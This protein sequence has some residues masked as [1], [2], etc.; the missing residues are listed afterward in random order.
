MTG[1]GTLTP[2][3]AYWIQ[4]VTNDTLAPSPLGFSDCG[5]TN[6]TGSV[7]T[8]GIGT[9]AGHYGSLT[10]GAPYTSMPATLTAGI[11]QPTIYLNLSNATEPTVATPVI[12]PNSTTFTG[13]ESVSITDS[14]SGAN[15]HYTLDGTTPTSSSPLYTST[16]MLNA[17]TTVNAIAVA[18]SY[19]PSSVASATYT[20]TGAALVSNFLGTAT[21]NNFTVPGSPVQFTVFLNY[22]DGVQTSITCV[23]A[24]PT[25]PCADTRGTYITSWTSS[26]TSVGTIASTGIFTPLSSGIGLVTNIQAHLTYTGG[27]TTTSLWAEY[28]ARSANTVTQGTTIKGVNIR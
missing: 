4:T 25:S 1:C 6:C 22:S 5:G 12:N 19:I 10:Y 20:L 23:G 2:S 21:S 11:D 28:V 24:S 16:L 7:P 15:I 13:T 27:T 3:T 14:T 18:T 17:T 26:A 8:N 9:Y